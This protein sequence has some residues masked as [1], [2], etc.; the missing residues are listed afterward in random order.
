[1]KLYDPII[2]RILSLCR[3][4]SVRELPVCDVDWRDLG[5]ENL[6]FRQDM[7]Y[8]LGGNGDRLFALGA[9]AVTDDPAL[10]TEDEIVLIGKDLPELTADT[11]YARIALVRVAPD[12]LG[13]GNALYN[14]V[15]RMEFVRYHVSPEGF[16]TRVS[17][18]NGTESARVSKQAL[19]KGLT[20]TKVGNLMLRQFHKNA[21]IV[22]VKLIFITDP[23]FPFPAL[24]D[25]VRETERITK[26]MDHILKNGMTDCESC[27]LQKVCEEVEGMKA[28]HFNMTNHKEN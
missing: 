6:I 27:S 17:L 15:K 16:M 12:T 2:S 9:T 10:V 19:E 18:I 23:T 24:K 5:K 8:E 25:A 22:S 1:M 13:E 4:A 28:L 14:A 26:A 7:A 11:S 3:Q 20:F 21:R